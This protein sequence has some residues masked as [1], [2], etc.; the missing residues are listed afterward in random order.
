MV[1]GMSRDGYEW[2]LNLLSIIIVGVV[3]LGDIPADNLVDIV[4]KMLFYLDCFL[5]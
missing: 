2:Q 5:C 3:L 4:D 1:E